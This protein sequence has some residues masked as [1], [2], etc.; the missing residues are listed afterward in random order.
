MSMSQRQQQHSV[1]KHGPR[2]DFRPPP[3]PEP[4]P[5]P[6]PSPEPSLDR[7]EPRPGSAECSSCFI[8]KTEEEEENAIFIYIS[9]S[10]DLESVT[11][12]SID[13]I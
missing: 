12:R 8:M 5:R 4:E 7:V 10:S 13:H 2:N 1:A 11:T 9:Y 3:K 6:G